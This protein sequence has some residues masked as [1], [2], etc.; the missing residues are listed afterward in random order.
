MKKITTL[1]L[2]ENISVYFLLLFFVFTSSLVGLAQ[3]NLNPISSGD[4]VDV[5]LASDLMTEITIADDNDAG[6]INV[7]QLNTSAAVSLANPALGAGDIVVYRNSYV[8]TVGPSVDAV[9]TILSVV[10]WTGG[11]DADTGDTVFDTCLL[12]TSPS[13]RDA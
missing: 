13:P 6:I 12:Y 8:P 10:D 1:S 9:V 3:T 5:F 2:P 7:S 11:I 4:K